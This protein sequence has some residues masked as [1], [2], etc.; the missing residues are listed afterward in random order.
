MEQLGLIF[1]IK[2]WLSFQLYPSVSPADVTPPSAKYLTALIVRDTDCSALTGGFNYWIR[3][4][5]LG[6][7]F[8]L[9][10]NYLN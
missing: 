8:L 7:F 4:P 10:N 6:F 3:E 9:P 5:W 1:L 2:T